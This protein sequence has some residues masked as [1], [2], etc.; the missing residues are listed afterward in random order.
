[1]LSRAC[2]AIGRGGRALSTAAP[3][4]KNVAQLAKEVPKCAWQMGPPRS[5]SC[6]PPRVPLRIELP[7][8]AA[9]CCCI[10]PDS[11]APRL[12]G[13][14]A[15]NLRPRPYS[16]F[17]CTETESVCEMVRKKPNR[18]SSASD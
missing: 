13:R 12:S 16:S 8:E 15:G 17:G 18:P 6:V 1:M 9:Q 7:D 5:V 11:L 4:K 10:H 2:R 3:A 14:E